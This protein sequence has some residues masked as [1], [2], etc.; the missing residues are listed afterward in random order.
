MSRLSSSA[1][2]TQQVYTLI[3]EQKFKEAI[4]IL[5][6]MKTQFP[7]SR[8][9]NSLIAYCRYASEEFEQAAEDY[10]NLMNQFPTVKDYRLSYIKSLYKA[11][12]FEE[13]ERACFAS[14]FA[15]SE[16]DTQFSHQL[17]LL[18]ATIKYEKQE[19]AGA[20]DIIQN[21]CSDEDPNTKIT[22][23]AILMKQQKY[24]R[25]TQLLIETITSG[26]YLPHVAY[27][28]ALCHF[29]MKQYVMSLKSI[30]DIQEKATR[31]YQETR[32]YMGAVSDQIPF[33]PEFL[34]DSMLIEALNL[35]AAIEYSLKNYDKAKDALD[36]MPMREEYELDHVTL[37]N[38]AILNVDDDT[39]NAI[40][41][42]F[43]LLSRPPFPKETVA[44]LLILLCKVGDYERAGELLQA[45]RQGSTKL[46]GGWGRIGG[47][48]TTFGGAG[49]R[50]ATGVVPSTALRMGTVPMTAAE[51]VVL[52]GGV[53]LTG[54]DLDPQLREFVE[55]SI[56]AQSNG[57][58][59]Y[60]LFQAL[61]AK[62]LDDV[63]RATKTFQ[64]LRNGIGTEQATFAV[65]EQERAVQVYMASMMSMAKIFWDLKKYP[66]T[67]RVLQS[68]REVCEDEMAF[69]LNLAHT[70]F[71]QEQYKVALTMYDKIVERQQ[72]T[73]ILDVTPIVL[74]NLCVCYVM[75]EQNGEGEE[76]IMRVDKEEE[77][78]L[79]RDPEKPVL[80]Q[81]IIDL[82][83]GTLY[84]SRRT[85]EFGIARTIKSFH[86]VEKKLNP[87]T[88]FYA[89]RNFAYM[90]E[91]FAKHQIALKEETQQQII[92]FLDQVDRHGRE[93]FAEN[94][95]V[96]AAEIYEG[97]YTGKGK[98]N[99]LL[100]VGG[101]SGS[102]S[103]SSSTSPLSSSRS[104]RPGGIGSASGD[105]RRRPGERGSSSMGKRKD[106][107]DGGSTTM[108]KKKPV[109]VSDEAR[110]IKKMLLQLWDTQ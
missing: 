57:F 29:M 59:G 35:K 48:G 36:E 9:A 39:D 56:V 81:C 44:N 38:T 64:E 99:D 67:A 96:A 83:I 32:G 75:G 33:D 40:N 8:A 97:E 93:M 12:K 66:Q 100:S 95:D 80:H 2:L 105:K 25:A 94:G 51:S 50:L 21:Q 7:R 13:A 20:T 28:I 104:T 102:S 49:L 74:A 60:R 11:G 22:E 45:E 27:N 23:A 1:S 78:A 47:N 30:E 77:N 6:R 107:E 63:K 37:H 15:A 41:K 34:K 26:G 24:D 71:V 18:H 110:L 42:L 14:R 4:G 70:L 88:W 90:C 69:Q 43:F 46:S 103:S 108:M 61:S 98:E 3:Q 85:F 16:D 55:A 5:S 72:E 86:P 52:S 31:D 82:V 17:H 54:V 73:S 58:E 10:E 109:T 76:I 62:Q 91:C 68:C 92:R 19:Y 65:K 79:I 87:G 89:K 53:Q 84:C 106:G 101:E